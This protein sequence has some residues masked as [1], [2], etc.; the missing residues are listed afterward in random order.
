MLV[1]PDYYSQYP[2]LGLLKLS[3]YHKNIGDT[4]ELV[5]GTDPAISQEPDVIYIT[6]L[7][8][9]A[10]QPVWK[11]VAFY[12]SLFPHSELW[13]GGLYASLMPEHA[14]LS[15]VHPSHIF[16]GVFREAEELLP[17]YGLV[18]E[19]NR[20][21]NA[22]IVFSSRGCIRNCPFCAVPSLEGKINSSKTTIKHLIWPGHKEVIFFDNNFF[23]G[24][25]WERI[26]DDVE[27]LGLRVDF[28]QG[29]DARLISRQVAKRIARLNVDKVVRLSYDYKEMGCSVKKATDFLKSEG[30][31]GRNILVYALYN[32][33]DDPQDFFNRMSDILA[34]GTVCYP[35][36]YEPLRTLYKNH[37]V[38]PRW[39]KN[40]LD[41]VQ[42]A[43]R[44]IGY[45]GAFVPHKGML[46]VKVQGCAT[47]EKAF[48]E[49]MAPLEVAG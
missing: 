30:I 27:E 3:T 24:P 14:A 7:F 25:Y 32:F 18:P 1:E 12:S 38:A 45:G 35:M 16:K 8:T 15:G 22:S 19:W 47:F 11:A 10:W 43:R 34:W 31:S 44:I 42:K 33:T 17:D 26:L 2:P 40:R 9:W 13:L 21:S 36:R 4:T 46:K 41:A 6:S 5:H 28:N 49:F 39:D 29:I 23:A 48:A 20:K 37:Y